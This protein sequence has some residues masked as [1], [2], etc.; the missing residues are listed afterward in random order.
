MTGHKLSYF[1]RTA[2]FGGEANHFR[3][4]TTN[5]PVFAHIASAKLRYGCVRC[6]E[7]SSTSC[8]GRPDASVS[9]SDSRR[10]SP[11]PVKFLREGVF[12][13]GAH[14]CA[15]SCGGGCGLG[16]GSSMMYCYSLGRAITADIR[17]HRE[18]HAGRPWMSKLL[19]EEIRAFLFLEREAE[20]EK[21]ESEV[22]ANEVGLG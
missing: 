17:I 15:M 10:S 2:M 19:S 14:Q 13:S 4:K 12:D 9:L 3:F 8:G 22:V 21:K 1:R 7:A 5:P 18:E 6:R 11:Y 20:R 16:S